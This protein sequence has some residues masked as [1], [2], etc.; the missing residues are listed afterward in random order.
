MCQSRITWFNAESVSTT[1]KLINI[2]LC[3]IGA[4]IVNT[5]DAIVILWPIIKSKEKVNLFKSRKL[6]KNMYIYKTDWES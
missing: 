4:C 6:K 5:N 2:V 1:K 3:P